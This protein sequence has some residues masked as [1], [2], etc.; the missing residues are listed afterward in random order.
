[1]IGRIIMIS[2]IIMMCE[3]HLTKMPQKRQFCLKNHKDDLYVI[4]IGNVFINFI[5][6]VKLN[7]KPQ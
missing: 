1:M 5:C 3:A 6:F 4:H 2:R 7:V